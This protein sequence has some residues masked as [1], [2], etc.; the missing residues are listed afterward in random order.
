MNKLRDA[1][2]AFLTENIQL[3]DEFDFDGLYA[4]AHG[5]LSFGDISNLTETLLRIGID[6]IPHMTKIPEGFL[7]DSRYN[8]SITIGSNIES[9]ARS[10]FTRA[11]ISELVIDGVEQIGDY[12]FFGCS[13][14]RKVT[15]TG[16]IGFI[17]SSAF[18]DTAIE[19][20]AL[21]SEVKML[22][23]E[24]FSNCTALQTVDLS[25]CL[26]NI[27]RGCFQK[28]RS[29]K[30]I[31]IPEGVTII[32][33][34][35]FDSCSSLTDVGLP[36]TLKTI[37]NNAFSWSGLKSVDVPEGTTTLKSACFQGCDSLN[38]VVLP[39]SLTECASNIL[40]Q[41]EEKNITIHCYAGSTAE[42]FA[43]G[44]GRKFKVKYM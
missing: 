26:T 15:L 29:L 27:P 14:L 10:A 8:G 39:S 36:S 21:P 12:A 3:I 2:A 41:T 34:E 20:V 32:S 1:V 33:A 13:K 35:A 38:Y 44:K 6:P 40:D 9:I 16:D 28:C 30:R 5:K 19:S 4:Q 25:E 22:A 42:E 17:G 23:S 11:S 24:A 37:A 18:A 43:K 31:Y 7:I